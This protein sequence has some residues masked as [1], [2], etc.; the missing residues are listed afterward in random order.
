MKKQKYVFGQITVEYLGHIVSREGVSVDPTKLKA[1]LDWPV[2]TTVKQ[3]RGFLGLTGYYRK[4]VPGYGKICQPLYY[5]TKKDNFVWSL[6]AN[7]AFEHLKRVMASPQVLTFPDFSK[8]FELECD[9]SGNGIE[10]VLQQEGRP[11]AFT[12]QA[13]GPRNQALFT[14][15]R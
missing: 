9:A 10:V 2:P 13:L 11:V 3:L 4:F 5:L 1:I 6:S 15:E 8:P 7:E 14:Y 12:S